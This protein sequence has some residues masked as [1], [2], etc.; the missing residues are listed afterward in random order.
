MPRKFDR[1]AEITESDD[2]EMD[3][4]VVRPFRLTMEQQETARE[5]QKRIQIQ[6]AQARSRRKYIR[7]TN[8]SARRHYDGD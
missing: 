2:L 4:V 3:A 8:H 5:A 7:M 6:E 1:A